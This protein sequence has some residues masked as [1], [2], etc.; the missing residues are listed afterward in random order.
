MG[1]EALINIDTART[2]AHVALLAAWEGDSESAKQI[3][4][5]MQAAMPKEPNIRTCLAMVLACQGKYSEAAE[6]LKTVLIEVPG[7]TSAKSLL[8][9]VM[10]SS[11]ETGWQTLLE[12]VITDGSDGSAVALARDIFS[13]HGENQVSSGSAA[14]AD[15]PGSPFIPYA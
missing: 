2:L 12:E 4:F 1:K 10:F 15:P 5:A 14:S 13:E 6:L 11:G 3:F 8:G 9:F 7:D